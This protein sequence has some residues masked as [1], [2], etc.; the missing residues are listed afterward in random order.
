MNNWLLIGG[1]A[2]LGG[3]L[4]FKDSIPLF[5]DKPRRSGGLVFRI[6]GGAPAPAPAPAAR[7]VDP[8]FYDPYTY[9]YGFGSGTIPG[10]QGHRRYR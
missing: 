2:V 5:T 9:D 6:P 3:L 8:G 10:I 1:I 7:S 4:F